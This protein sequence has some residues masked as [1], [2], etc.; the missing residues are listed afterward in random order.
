MHRCS[1]QQVDEVY[2]YIY[3]YAT[4]MLVIEAYVTYITAKATNIYFAYRN[5]LRGRPA[6][7]GMLINFFL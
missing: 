6:C 5:S 4:T 7:F 1:R 3:S 2:D